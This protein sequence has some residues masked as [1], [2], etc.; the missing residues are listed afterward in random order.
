[1]PDENRFMKPV[2]KEYASLWTLREYPTRDSEWTMERKFA[3]VKQ[4]G[5]TGICGRF[6]PEAIPLCRKFGLDYI[7]TINVCATDGAEQLR[8]AAAWN[9]QRI[10]V[11]LCAHDTPP[12]V[13]ATIWVELERLAGQMG[14]V[15]D[16]ELHRDT[17][18]ETPEKADAIA[19]LCEKTTGHPV[20]LC[21]DYSHLAVVKH[22]LPPYAARLLNRPAQIARA[23]QMHFRPFNGHHAQ[24][25]ATDGRGNLTP[26]FISYL[27]FVDGLL[28]L[29]LQTARAGDVLHAC[30]ENGPLSFGY[31]LSCFPDVWRDAIIIRDETRARWNR[32]IESWQKT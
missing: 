28:A 12:E 14:L 16:L 6:I 18:T 4:Q 5:F 1:M 9:P 2:L 13:A 30:P 29:W 31:A 10:T 3:E 22:L 23:R 25:P 20:R 7:I 8:R 19:A 15:L 17:A 26:E 32:Q 21:L 24:V 11:H 27:E